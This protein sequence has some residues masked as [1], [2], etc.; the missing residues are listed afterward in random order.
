MIDPVLPARQ[1]PSLVPDQDAAVDIWSG[2][3]LRRLLLYAHDTYGLGHLRRNLAIASHLL[4]TTEQLQIVLVSGS[5][6]AARFPMPRGLSLVSLPSVVK[7]APEEYASRDGQINFGIVSRARAAIIADIARRFQPDALLVD[8]AP[9]GMKGELL[10]TFEV[11]R[12]HVPE[13]RIV[14][15]LRDVLDDPATVR[16]TWAAQ[17]VLNTLEDVYHRILVYGSREL[18]DVGAAY[19]IPTRLRSRISYCGYVARGPE[20]HV[21]GVADEGVSLPHGP[22]VLGTAG[23]GEDGVPVLRA[24]LRAAAA[25]GVECLLVTGPLMPTR[26]RQELAAEAA[27]TGRA[28]VVEFVTDLQR[29]MAQAAAI[30]TMGGY[31]SLGEAVVTGVP[32]VV[33]PRTWPRREQ[34]IRA[35]LFADRGLVRVVDPGD[36]LAER[37]VVPLGAALKDGVRSVT[38]IDLD[39]V[40][41]VRDALLDEV[42]RPRAEHAIGQ[43]RPHAVPPALRQLVPA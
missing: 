29:V 20:A 33:V 27:T 16:E 18:L 21:P 42:A 19:G 4:R 13:T 31:N 12:R 15:G 5:P 3:R 36:D 8:H 38:R 30:V 1:M 10:P 9:Q 34:A 11:L 28:H 43:D 40:R 17:G 37:L 35:A 25:L 14:L 26:I 6:V 2:Q 39:G 23:G 24:T 7:V 32:T 22:Y 41:R